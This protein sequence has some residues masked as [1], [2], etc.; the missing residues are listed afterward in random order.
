MTVQM[1]RSRSFAPRRIWPI[2]VWVLV[3]LLVT[4]A[5][6]AQSS[7][8]EQKSLLGGFSPYLSTGP[9]TTIQRVRAS[10]DTDF[11]VSE[12]SANTLTNLGWLFELGVRS[13]RVEELPGQ[14]RF[15]LAGGILI[16]MN[17]SSTIGSSVTIT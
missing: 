8:R 13:P 9:Y 4:Q 7:R 14:P 15:N 2:L 12:R 3:S 5:A 1:P 10:V 11:G 6:L 17:T 16:P